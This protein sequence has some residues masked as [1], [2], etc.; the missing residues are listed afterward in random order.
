MLGNPV[1]G[2]VVG[3]FTESGVEVGIAVEGLLVCCEGGGDGLVV[4]FPVGDGVGFGLG[5]RVGVCVGDGVGGN[6]GNGVGF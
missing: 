6:D 5:N 2:L 3:V 1:E 4:G